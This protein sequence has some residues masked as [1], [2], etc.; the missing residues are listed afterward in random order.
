MHEPV[1]RT[2]LG[3]IPVSSAGVCY[4]HEHVVI[5]QSFT[6]VQYPDFLLNDLDRIVPELSQ[7]VAAG[8]RT[9]VDAMPCGGGR[10]V[11]KLAEVSKRSGV[12]I[13]CPTGLHL[14]K[15]YPPGHWGERYT[16]AE[17][18]DIF[19]DEIELGIDENDTNGPVIKRTTHRAGLIKVSSGLNGINDYERKLFEAA[20]MAQLR[21]GVAIMTHAEQGTGGLEQVALLSQLG[22]RPERIV[23]SHT[24]RK[25][26]LGYHREL[27]STGVFLEYDSAFRWKTGDENPTRD[28]LEKLCS[29]GYDK[30]LVVGMDAARQSYWRSYGG[31]PGLTFLLDRFF[32]EMVQRGFPPE[33]VQHILVDNPARAHTISRSA[34][35][36]AE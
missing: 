34:A 20:A 11:R 18:A 24:D 31:S 13:L 26:D 2:V 12:H 28:L 27:L 17:I 23:L 25:P 32:P 15:Y 21:T 5:D 29:E 33:M 22:V 9:M 35:A 30:Q 1:I 3:D 16:A 36:A 14:K 4:S 19:A 8:G 10:N 6:I 7:W